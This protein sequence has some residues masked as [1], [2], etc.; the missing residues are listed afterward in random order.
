[1]SAKV[2]D[3]VI[4][5]QTP[6]EN[7]LLGVHP[8][9][10]FTQERIAELRGK[11]GGE[12]WQGFFARVRSAADLGHMPFPALVYLLTGERKYFDQ[13]RAGLLK[14]I[15]GPGWPTDLRKEG[16]VWNELL[17]KVALG[18]DWLYHEL[19]AETLTAAQECLERHGRRHFEA[20]SKHELYNA[21]TYTCN[22]LPN[23]LANIAA[24]GF[25]L[26]GEVGDIAPWLRFVMEKARL[27]TD[28]LAPDGASQEGICYGGFYTE[29]YMRILD[30][31]RELMGWDFFRNNRHLQNVPY[32]YLYSMLPRRH[33]SGQWTHL[34]FGDG[35]RY[36]WFGPDYYLH[37]LAGVYRNPYAE[38]VAAVQLGAGANRDSGAYLNLI[39]YDPTIKPRSPRQLPTLR[40]FEDKDIVIMRSGWDGEEAV[41]GF[42]CGPHSGHHALKNYPQCIGGGH[43][44]A[45]AGSFLLFAHGD[46]LISDAW[47]AR[48]FTAYRNTVLVNGVG[49]TGEGGDWFECSELRRER[50]GPS[51][52]RVAPGARYDYVIGNVAPAYEHKAGL[53]KYLRHVLYVKGVPK[54]DASRLGAPPYCWVIV[55]E[56]TAAEPSTFDLFFHAWEQEFKADRPFQPVAENVWKTGG[57]KG[58]LQI[59]ALLPGDV[60]GFAE[61]QQQQGI[62][63]HA[64]RTMCILRL[65]NRKPTKK[66]V[67]VTVLEAYPAAGSPGL[68]PALEKKGRGTY[69]S[70]IGPRGRARF[71]FAPGQA[72][73]AEPIF[74]PADPQRRR[75]G[76]TPKGR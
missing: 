28:A 37:K 47:Y 76:R 25:A 70:L 4:N 3:D 64:N 56:L 27:M 66:A 29:F 20:L 10:H 15:H 21:G 41:F 67:F 17:Y 24:A 71:A 46:W 63:A 2:T 43:M 44:A 8:R 32:F 54:R 60:E 12:P 74:R 75:R 59:T 58:A 52:L 49:Q 48:K 38:W 69:L 40:H 16:F 11:I 45:G 22:H 13:A 9:I 14:I 5:G 53:K 72:D 26:Y 55:D 30:L 1:M 62:G 61:V 35:V 57:S 50:R 68:T 19:D 6:L 31:V 7:Q 39:W 51:L 23:C 73:P 36:N 65:R 42:I 18:Y 34:C 33:V